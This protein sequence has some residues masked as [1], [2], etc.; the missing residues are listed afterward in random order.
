LAA[1]LEYFEDPTPGIDGMSAVRKGLLERG[2]EMPLATNMCVTSFN[3]IP[4]AIARNG[5]QV[6]LG[7]HHYWGG[8]RSVVELGRICSTFG[9]GLSMHSNSHLGISLL[10]MT[11]L[12]AVIPTM[13]YDADTH[14]PWLHDD[15][16]V[17]KGGKIRFVDGCVVVPESPGLGFEIDRAAL[18]RGHER[19]QRCSY[20]DRDDVGYMRRTVD[21]N[22]EKLLP[23][24]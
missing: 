23:R 11:H 19:F 15:D 1:T 5:V 16:E 2:I 3:D 21:P 20:R 12:A 8:L 13:T 4:E 7:D 17:I 14:Y 6:I 9:I 22:W 18:H 10:A 24:W